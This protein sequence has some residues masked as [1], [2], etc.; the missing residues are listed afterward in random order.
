M[1]HSES[2]THLTLALTSY[3]D[4]SVSDEASNIT[5]IG[6][7][8]MSKDEFLAFSPAWNE[9][10]RLHR[11]PVP[12]HMTDFVRPH[13]KH[14]GM[15]SEMKLALFTEAARLI[16]THK[17]YS[18]A[19]TVPQVDFK[20]LLSPEVCKTVA[21][22]YALAFFAAVIF[23]QGVA[24]ASWVLNTLGDRISYLVDRGSAFPEQLNAAHSVVIEWERSTRPAVHT[25]AL[26]FDTDDRVPALQAADL[27]AWAARRQQLN[28][29][30]SEFLPLEAVL[31][32]N[33]MD[34]IGKNAPHRTVAIPLDGIEMFAKPINNWI[35]KH[36]TIPALTDIVR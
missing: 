15:Q 10:L 29:L 32:E 20:R 26:A 21:G 1:H 31:R 3:L 34:A 17:L 4:D 35:T 24:H 36:G 19:V 8:V 33:Q 18:F 2:P 23:N 9:M 11:I 22:P 12:L 30:G 28:N 25:G 7:P 16:N 5:A 14:A 27:I 13:G 6:G